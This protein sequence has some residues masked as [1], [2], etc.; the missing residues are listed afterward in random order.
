MQK[1]FIIT[2]D[3]NSKDNYRLA[4]YLQLECGLDLAKSFTT[5]NVEQ[6]YEQLSIND[7]ILAYK[8]NALLYSY[9]KD[10]IH[11]GITMD[12]FYNNDLF[13][14]TIDGFNNIADNR[15]VNVLVVWLDLPTKE[16]TCEM[17][18]NI[19]SFQKTLESINY[20]YFNEDFDTICKIMKEYI[21]TDSEDIR[22]RILE[23]NK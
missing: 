21:E 11:S 4:E 13:C 1:I 10:N 12:E 14:M 18:H 15:L 5:G 22:E 2:S 16:I 23:E 3:K 20:M 19:K 6:Y 17:S 7:V 8:N 9:S